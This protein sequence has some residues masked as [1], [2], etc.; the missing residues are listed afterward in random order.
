[1]CLHDLSVDCG[2]SVGGAA[3]HSGGCI[4][5]YPGLHTTHNP[6]EVERFEQDFRRY[7]TRKIGLEAVMR[8]RCTKGIQPCTCAMGSYYSTM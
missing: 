8:V 1:M 2:L 3:R 7:L 6:V 4:Y 5:A